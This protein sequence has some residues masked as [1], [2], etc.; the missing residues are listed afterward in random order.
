MKVKDKWKCIAFN[1]KRLK[2]EFLDFGKCKYWLKYGDVV[3]EVKSKRV[4]ISSRKRYNIYIKAESKAKIKVV[5]Y[6]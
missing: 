1:K 2:I 5:K 6:K 4:N 3:T